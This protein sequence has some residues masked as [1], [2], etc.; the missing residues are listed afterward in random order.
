M[1][2]VVLNVDRMMV[3]IKQLQIYRGFWGW[4]TSAADIITTIS[5]QS[6]VNGLST[7]SKSSCKC[8]IILWNTQVNTRD[9]SLWQ[10][11][12]FTNKPTGLRLGCFDFS[13]DIDDSSQDVHSPVRVHLLFGSDKVAFSERLYCPF[14]HARY[15]NP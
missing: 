4:P 15:E 14:E 13:I 2:N 12:L 8:G 5:C 11:D 10:S 6:V 1:K 7:G 3:V 9:N